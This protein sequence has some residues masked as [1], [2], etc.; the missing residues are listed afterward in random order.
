MGMLRTALFVLCLQ[1]FYGAFSQ[2]DS[3]RY[4]PVRTKYTFDWGNNKTSIMLTQYG[5]STGLVMIHLHDDEL[6]SDK[7]AQTILQQRGGLLIEL[8]NNGQRLMSFKKS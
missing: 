7:A 2:T 6:A 8:E 1:T 3:I 5:P 4:S